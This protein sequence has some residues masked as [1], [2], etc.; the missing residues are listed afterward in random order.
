MNKLIETLPKTR[1]V[2]LHQQW[3]RCGKPSCRCARG[4]LHGPYWY[5][6]WR[7]R[8]RLHK[9]YVPRAE[10]AQM[11]ALVAEHRAGL[12]L[13]RAALRLYRQLWREQLG[14][15]RQYERWL[16]RP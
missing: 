4:A 12:A 13:Q 1:A 6:F 15:M 8:G 9:R 2:S 3:T 10:L 16:R 11:R 14:E 5:L 7:E